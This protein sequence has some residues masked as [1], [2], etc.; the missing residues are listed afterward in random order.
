MFA[1]QGQDERPTSIPLAVYKLYV[2]DGRE[3]PVRGLRFRGFSARNLKD[4]IAA[5]DE[6]FVFHFIDSG[7]PFA[8]MEGTYGAETSVIAPSVL[9]EDVEFKGTEEQRP[10]LPVVPH[11][12]FSRAR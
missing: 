7:S 12:Y 9:M 4:I 6:P 1:S 10:R 8:L 2:A 3:E 11:P 5:G